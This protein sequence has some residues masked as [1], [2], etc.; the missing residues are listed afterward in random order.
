MAEISNNEVQETRGLTSRVSPF[1]SR[2]QAPT[3]LDVTGAAKQEVRLW[4]E[5]TKLVGVGGKIAQT[6]KQNTDKIQ[7]ANIIKAMGDQH[8]RLMLEVA[9]NLPSTDVE[10]LSDL[11]TVLTN[12]DQRH[13]TDFRIGVTGTD[14][15]PSVTIKD[16]PLDEYDV[17][18]SQKER[19]EKYYYDLERKKKEYFMETLPGVVSTKAN[20]LLSEKTNDLL[21]SATA[22]FRN[23]DM[24]DSGQVS[25]QPTDELSGYQI[26]EKDENGK[27]YL[28]DN[29]SQIDVLDGGAGVTGDPEELHSKKLNMRG[30]LELRKI[31]K[32]YNEELADW[33]AIGGLGTPEKALSFQREFVQNILKKQL[34]ADMQRDEDGAYLKVVNNEYY[35][36]QDLLWDPKGTVNKRQ[37]LMQ[38]IS[39]NSTVSDDFVSRYQLKLRTEKEAKRDETL[40]D[41]LDLS[42]ANVDIAIY[43]KAFINDANNSRE[44]VEAMFIN[45]G[46]KESQAAAYSLAWSFKQESALKGVANEAEDRVSLMIANE[47]ALNPRLAMESYATRNTDKQFSYHVEPVKMKKHLKGLVDKDIS[48][49]SLSEKEKQEKKK[50]LYKAIDKFPLSKV[51]SYTN[52][53]AAR[54]IEAAKALMINNIDH[55]TGTEEGRK[56]L[57]DTFFKKSDRGTYVRDPEKINA[58]LDAGRFGIGPE[59][60]AVPLGKALEIINREA[61]LY[62][63][64]N[65]TGAYLPKSSFEQAVSKY[66]S[67]MDDMIGSLV[68]PTKV[69]DG[70]LNDTSNPFEE[71]VMHWLKGRPGEQEKANKNINDF[72]TEDQ[73]T[74]MDKIVNSFNRLQVMALSLNPDE[75]TK[76]QQL[77]MYRQ[78]LLEPRSLKERVFNVTTGKSAGWVLK[79]LNERIKNLDVQNRAVTFQR[80]CLTPDGERNQT[81]EL[82]K[83]Q[84]YGWKATDKG[85]NIFKSDA[86]MNRMNSGMG[87][88][89]KGG[90]E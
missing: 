48:S 61:N 79:A 84:S 1:A 2:K 37:K 45:E 60:L 7:G 15:T 89:K 6:W 82:Q 4:E 72:M 64:S 88:S 28:V 3:P 8:E 21:D 32:E 25:I 10:N 29:S 12:F 70:S 39:L 57:I 43:D 56:N 77:K 87:V 63:N 58:H 52:Q 47:F 59:G 44:D 27:N 67:N 20:Y 66:Q 26:W 42:K 65:S 83:F 90:K 41:Q 14:G 80:E 76:P 85:I 38:K 24:Y 40:K 74:R 86:L 5:T 34:H 81:C 19:V 50:I 36:E 35:I 31:F 11:S 54:D 22:I 16:K 46:I 53:A 49:T 23:S 9:E 62:S 68:M 51:Q 71:S 13:S 17:P 33:L 75:H 73:V 78:Q 69:Y 18:Y 55:E 30:D